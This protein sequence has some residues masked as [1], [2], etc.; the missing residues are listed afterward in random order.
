LN[1]ASNNG[2]DGDKST[3]SV[4]A[5]Q[6]GLFKLALPLKA[7]PASASSTH[8]NVTDTEQTV[9]NTNQ[10]SPTLFLLH[11]RQPLSFIA[12]LI[13]TEVAAHEEKP[14]K[15]ITFHGLPDKNANQNESKSHWASSTELGNF[16]Q[17]AAQGREFAI[18]LHEAGGSEPR[19]IRVKVPT[20]DERT[21]FLREQL[22][23]ISGE[24]RE[25]LKIKKDA[26]HL[27]WPEVL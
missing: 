14:P 21:Y 7:N 17:E 4:Y 11:P 22:K 24:M 5:T 25:L 19:R 20:F 10:D 13:Q 12:S 8:G 16:I 23:K 15:N 1:A 6:S 27:G 18:A 26:D 9:L 3:G 2:K